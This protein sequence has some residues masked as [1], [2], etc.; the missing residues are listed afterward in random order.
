MTTTEML[1]ALDK[2]MRD[3]CARKTDLDR[4]DL[5]LNIEIRYMADS[6]VAAVRVTATENESLTEV[7]GYA[8]TLEGALSACKA[9]ADLLED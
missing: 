3:V 2:R 9:Q 8:E 5:A 4:D 7:T 6:A 1:A